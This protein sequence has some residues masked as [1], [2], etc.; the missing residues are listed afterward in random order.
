MPSFPVP[1][2]FQGNAVIQ[3]VE[4]PSNFLGYLSVK[5]NWFC[6]LVLK[7]VLVFD[8]QKSGTSGNQLLIL[9]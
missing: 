1:G 2:H 9:E 4:L 5:V 3:L 8:L 6:E 7:I